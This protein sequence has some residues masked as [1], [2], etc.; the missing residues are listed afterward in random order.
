M[1]KKENENEKEKEKGPEM[2][3]LGGQDEKLI[4]TMQNR[5]S[6]MQAIVGSIRTLCQGL[7]GKREQGSSSLL[8]SNIYSLGVQSQLRDLFVN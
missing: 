2:L 1:K 4:V 5:P 3:H 7:S 8:D 6:L